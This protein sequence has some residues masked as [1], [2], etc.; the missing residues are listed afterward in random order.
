[1]LLSVSKILC[2][3][4]AHACLGRLYQHI[5]GNLQGVFLLVVKML[6]Y[7]YHGHGSA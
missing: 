6:L 2:V 4:S 3:Y 1:M 7:D 5:S